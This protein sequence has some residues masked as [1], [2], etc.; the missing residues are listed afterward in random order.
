MCRNKFHV[1]VSCG[2]LKNM[3]I[4]GARGMDQQLRALAVLVEDLG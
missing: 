2:T 4:K 1:V 3:Y